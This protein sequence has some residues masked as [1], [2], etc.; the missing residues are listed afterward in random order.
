MSDGMDDDDMHGM[1]AF[2][3]SEFE[4]DDDDDRETISSL[5]N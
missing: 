1:D 3:P 5:L 4:V 2:D